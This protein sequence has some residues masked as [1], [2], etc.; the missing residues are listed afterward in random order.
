VTDLSSYQVQV[1]AMERW[2]RQ[3]AIVFGSAALTQ[4]T[5]KTVQ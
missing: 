3:D 5:A 4:N 2:Q 1:L